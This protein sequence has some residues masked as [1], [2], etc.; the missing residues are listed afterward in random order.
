VT[1]FE[2]FSGI[3]G[4][5]Y[6]CFYKHPQNITPHPINNT[7]PPPSE[8]AGGRQ[9]SPN[10]QKQTN[11]T[12]ETHQATKQKSYRSIIALKVTQGV[13]VERK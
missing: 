2:K 10:I 3:A 13:V 4:C 5:K 9:K 8:G 7:S 6:K 12:K 1:G 11:K